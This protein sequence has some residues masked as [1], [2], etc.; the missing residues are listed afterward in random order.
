MQRL[1]VLGEFVRKPMSVGAVAPSSWRLA[2]LITDVA[3]LRGASV[4]VEFGPG[5][6]A[7]TEVILR[8]LA[9]G[10]T[11]L[12]IEANKSFVEATRA[13]LPGVTVI[14]D[15]AVSVRAHLESLG[16][17]SC[18]CIVSGLPFASFPPSLQTEILSA[19]ADV[20]TPGGR[21]VTFAYTHG[22]AWPP[23]RRFRRRLLAAFSEVK[24]TQTIW[25]NIPPAYVYR[26]IK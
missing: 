12:A 23:A 3:E 11:F 19:A 25:Q 8:K 22:L 4:V 6:G 9:P 21:F 5:T 24:V 18:D 15:S 14:H 2:E 16:H 10:A 7:F 17:S 20:L 13:R 26:A 1:H